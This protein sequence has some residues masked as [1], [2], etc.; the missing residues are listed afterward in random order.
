MAN[1]KWTVERDYIKRLLSQ[2][3]VADLVETSTD[4][5]YENAQ[6][7][8]RSEAFETGAY[9]RSFTKRM[10]KGKDGY[11]PVGVVV[12]NSPHWIFVE[13]G[14]RYQRA[15]SVIRR[16]VDSTGLRTKKRKR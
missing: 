14:T 10:E 16:A 3:G 13:Y 4:A 12:T 9:A 6:T 15:K 7:L 8:A 1:I 5:V 2:D 11:R